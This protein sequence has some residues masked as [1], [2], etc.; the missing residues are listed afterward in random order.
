M[1]IPG[2][3]S[4]MIIKWNISVMAEASI[5]TKKRR[6]NIA[7]IKITQTA[8]NSNDDFSICFSSFSVFSAYIHSLSESC[9]VRGMRPR[10]V[11]RV[12]PATASTYRNVG[13]VVR[14]EKI[15]VGQTL[16]VSQRTMRRGMPFHL[17]NA[18]HQT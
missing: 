17:F 8:I 10:G 11:E 9:D 7:N 2:S 13:A 12:R 1:G 5:T 15:R 16:P 6:T 14:Y 3:H 4:M 18:P